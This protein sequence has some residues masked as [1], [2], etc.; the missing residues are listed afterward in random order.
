VALYADDADNQG[1]LRRAVELPGLPAS[2][3]DYF[4]KRLWEP[5]A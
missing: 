4:R 3:R 2:W 1:L 5:D